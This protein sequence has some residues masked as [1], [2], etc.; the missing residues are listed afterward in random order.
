MG[1]GIIMVIS[2]DKDFRIKDAD[3]AWDYLTYHDY[4]DYIQT[5]DSESDRQNAM[6]EAKSELRQEGKTKMWSIGYGSEKKHFICLLEGSL[7][8]G[9]KTNK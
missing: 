7:T 9:E 6:R 4:M 8:G 1:H 5:F 3:R 2:T